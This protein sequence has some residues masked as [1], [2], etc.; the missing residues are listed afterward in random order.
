MRDVAATGDLTRKV[1]LRSRPVGRR[2]RAAARGG[3]QHADRV[4]RALSGGSGAARAALVARPPVHGDR[5]RDPQPADDH[6]G[7]APHPARAPIS[8]PAE[9]REAVADIDERDDTPQPHRHRGARLRQ[10]DPFDF[11]ESSIN[12][13][14]RASAA[15]AWAGDAETSV[16]LELDAVAAAH[17]HRRRAAAHGARQHPDQRASRGAGRGDPRRRNARHRRRHR[18][19]RAATATVTSIVSIQDRGVGIAPE[20]MARIFDPYFTTRRAGTGLGLPISKNIIEGMGGTLAVAE[21]ARRRHRSPHRSA[22]SD[23]RRHTRERHPR[24]DSAGRR[25]G[26]DPQAPG[27]GAARRGARG[28]RSDVGARMRRSSSSRSP[29]DLL[30]VDNLMPG[31]TGLEL[32]REIAQTMP[33]SERPQVL[34]MT[35]H[36][37]VESAHRGDEAR[38]ARLPAEAVRGRR[39]AR[40]RAATRSST[41]ASAPSASI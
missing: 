24:L 10:A 36:A 17:R 14:C 39:T 33:P 1:S 19:G 20:D 30:V 4:G 23:R 22:A 34:M 6:Q 25:R 38:R 27:A 29:F 2:R 28:R 12:D 32:I 40:A 41:S 31:M 37:T 21:P 9:R 18:S 15:A 7:D 13:I 3:V 11:A 16:A 5:A 26:E 35:A 8:R